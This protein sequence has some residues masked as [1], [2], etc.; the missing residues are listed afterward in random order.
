MKTKTN[1]LRQALYFIT[2]IILTAAVQSCSEE[3]NLKSPTLTTAAAT[4]ITYTTAITGGAITSTGGGAI[5]AKGICIST[6]PS[7]TID[8]ELVTNEGAGKEA[9][10][11]SL[12]NLLPNTDYYVRAYATNEVGT[13]YGNEITFSTNELGLP[14]INTTAATEITDTRF[15]TGA[16]IVENGGSTVTTIGLCW[17]KTPNPTI[18]DSKTEFAGTET[19]STIIKG[20]LLPNT[21][22]YVRAYA[23]NGIGTGYGNE[24]TVNTAAVQSVTDVDGNVYQAVVIGNRVWLAENLKVTKYTNGDVIGTTTSGVEN[25]ATPKYQWVYDNNEAN[26][27][28]YGRYYTYYAAMDERKVCPAGT[29]VSTMD[30]WMDLND[31]VNGGGF[32]LRTTGT[33]TWIAPNSSAT[34][35]IGFNAVGSGYR[36]QFSGFHNLKEYAFYLT[37]RSETGNESTLNGI[38]LQNN[39][40][41]IWLPALAKK[42]GYSIRCVKD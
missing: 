14:I 38:Y 28:T 41:S 1:L 10:V 40:N 11:S 29:H 19:F 18:N 7:P 26:A 34:N 37:E 27:A 16:S 22:Y 42:S 17:S 36:S 24:V 12:E 31:V 33:D 13:S 5:T 21:T 32:K 8:A 39:D 3:E 6:T 35:E 25:E 30:D 4:E 15:T 23:T 20:G 9:F 2:L